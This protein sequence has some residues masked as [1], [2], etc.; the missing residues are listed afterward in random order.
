MMTSEFEEV[1][2]NIHILL[3]EIKDVNA[4]DELVLAI[5]NER[6]LPI[7]QQ[8]ISIC[9]ENGLDFSPHLPVFVKLVIDGNYME[10]FEAMTVI[11]NLEESISPEISDQAIA[12]LDEAKET[13]KD[14]KA[15]YIH[16]LLELIPRMVRT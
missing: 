15:G 11:E 16:E 1:K 14:E 2:T 6:Y 4:I 5:Q 8:L 7:R 9:W 10:S 12:L 13:A 3:S